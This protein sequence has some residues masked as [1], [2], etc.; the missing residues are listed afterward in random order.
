M[1]EPTNTRDEEDVSDSSAS[2][3]P[4]PTAPQS[5]PYSYLR[6]E[7]VESKYFPSV[8]SLPPQTLCW[9]LLSKG[10]GKAPQLYE[11]ARILSPCENEKRMLVQYPK[12]STYRVRQSNLMPVLEHEENLVLIASETNDYRRTSIVHTLPKDDFLEIGCDFG[13]LVDSVDA[14]TRLGVDKSEESIRIA[15]ERYPD[16]DFLLGD[17]FEDEMELA[18][19]TVVAIDINGNRMLPAV[20]KC[21]Q[22]AIDK[23]SPRLLI[24]KSRELYALHMKQQANANTTK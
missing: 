16:R 5:K 1:T 14:K 20:L 22:L 10:K 4:Q 7:Q 13:I 8:A 11:R 19:P 21:I 3:L 2:S 6:Y 9:V 12:G 17:I 15:K 23:W 24:V 18:R